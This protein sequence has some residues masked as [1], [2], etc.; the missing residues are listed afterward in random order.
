MRQKNLS[1]RLIMPEI[2]KVKAKTS[3]FFLANQL[4]WNGMG[5]DSVTNMVIGS[6]VAWA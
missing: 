5:W 2:S 4:N 3:S 6:D 1:Q